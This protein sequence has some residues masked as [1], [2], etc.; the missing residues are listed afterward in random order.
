LVVEPERLNKLLSTV[1]MKRGKPLLDSAVGEFTPKGVLFRE[2]KADAILVYAIYTPQYFLEY[3]SGEEK[4]PLTA[5]LLERLKWGFKDDKISLRTEGGSLVLQGSRETYR[6]PLIDLGERAPFPYKFK[7]SEYG[8]VPE[9]L[10]PLVAVLLPEGELDLPSADRYTFKCDGKK[11]SV[12]IEEVGT[13]ERVLRP[14]RVAVMKEASISFDGDYLQTVLNNVSGE[15]WLLLTEGG[16]VLCQRFKD[17]AVTY[18]LARLLE[19]GEAEKV[20]APEAP[21]AAKTEESGASEEVIEVGSE[22]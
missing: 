16:L 22:S 3:E 21:E 15:A 14:S 19:E 10:E 18:A 2:I 7:N 5:T 8:F 4:V 6:E 12:V 13:F 11:L 9:N 17:H 20:A 1:L